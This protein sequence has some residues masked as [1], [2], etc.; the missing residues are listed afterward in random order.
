MVASRLSERRLPARDPQ[1]EQ[2]WHRVESLAAIAV[3]FLIGTHLILTRQ[4]A[5]GFVPGVALWAVWWP[6]VA[7]IR[8]ARWTFLFGFLALANGLLLSLNPGLR[9]VNKV[10]QLH[11]SLELIGVLACAGAMVWVIKVVGF[12]PAGVAYGLGMLANANP[13]GTNNARDPWRLAY[14]LPIIVIVLFAAAWLKATRMQVAA[15]LAMAI[16]SVALGSRSVF[17]V[18]LIALVILSLWALRGQRSK[19]L[20]MGATVLSLGALG[21]AAYNLGQALLLEGILGESAR[22]R[23]EYQ[24]RVAGE[25]ILGGRPEIAATLGLMRDRIWGYG[26]GVQPH[27]G[28][29]Q[30]ARDAMFAIGYDPRNGYFENYMFG[31]VFRLHSVF[32]DLWAAFGIMGLVF[33]FVLLYQTIRIV[34][35]GPRPGL[36]DAAALFLALIFVWNF[37]FGP[38]YSAI[39]TLIIFLGLAWTRAG[40]P[41]R[42][43]DVPIPLTPHTHHSARAI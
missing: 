33:A 11:A 27:H 22:Q 36:A 6:L 43:P 19:R 38:W 18:Q 10:V 35:A 16:M 42:L 9:T 24:I 23:T 40:P 2:N 1:T 29:L 31:H 20:S 4:F 30:V 25:L 39:D 3:A 21:L 28:D 41:D 17:A 8:A 13:A 7:R 5:A 26:V 15:L 14:S 34:Q 12:G 32:G 37:A